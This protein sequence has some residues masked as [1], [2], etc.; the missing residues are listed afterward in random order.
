MRFIG[1]DLHPVL[2][3]GN[4]SQHTLGAQVRAAAGRHTQPPAG[5]RAAPS[6]KTTAGGGE[7]RGCDRGKR[8]TG[9]KR[10]GLVETRGLR[11][12]VIVTAT[13][14]SENAGAKFVCARLRGGAQK[15]RRLW[16]AGGYTAGLVR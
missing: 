12:A 2:G 9:R 15:L 3:G 10:Q 8:S 14:V 5:C 13:A 7:A 16:V 6:V 4:A 11:L 1:V